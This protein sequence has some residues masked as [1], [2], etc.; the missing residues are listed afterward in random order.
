MLFLV[1]AVPDIRSYPLVRIAAASISFSAL[2]SGF[3][4]WAKQT[5]AKWT[6]LMLLASMYAVLGTAHLATGETSNVVIGFALIGL[7]VVAYLFWRSVKKNIF[8]EI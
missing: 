3:G 7:P 5:W 8:D 2:I 4:I 6:L 1:M